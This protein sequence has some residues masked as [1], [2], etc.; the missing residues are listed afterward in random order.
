M[1]DSVRIPTTT[2]SLITLNLTFYSE[3]DDKGNAT[4]NREVINNIYKDA[5]SGAQRDMVVFSEKQNVSSDLV[6]YRAATVI[7]GHETHTRTGFIRLPVESLAK[8]GVQASSEISI[9]VTHL[10]VFGWY[11]NEYGSYVNFLT[12]LVN[13]I[14]L[15]LR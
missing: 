12:K 11:D 4:I 5:A 15:S 13:H 6:G 7:E 9:P 2:V 8:Y 1:A 10:K 3:V 14:N